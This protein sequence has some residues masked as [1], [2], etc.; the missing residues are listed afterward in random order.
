MFLTRR[1]CVRALQSVRCGSC[2]SWRAAGLP[3]QASTAFEH[4]ARSGS[5]ACC[6]ILWKICK[7]SSQSPGLSALQA[8]AAVVIAPLTV[9][10][11]SGATLTEQVDL[12][13]KQATA[14]KAATSGEICQTCKIALCTSMCP[15]RSCKRLHG[16]QQ[17]PAFPSTTSFG[18]SS[19]C[20]TALEQR[21]DAA[22]HKVLSQDS[23][24]STSPTCAAKVAT[25]SVWGHLFASHGDQ[26]RQSSRPLTALLL[27]CAAVVAP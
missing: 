4:T 3:A 8:W 22:H 18:T 2:S 20:C 13:S 19:H 1:S 9:F 14:P 25:H 6:S 24:Y 12:N 17:S 5:T 21:C 27:D 23:V 16:F 26:K 10:A 11:K 7:A 15:F